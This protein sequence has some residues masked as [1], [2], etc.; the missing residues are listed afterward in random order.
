MTVLEVK[1]QFLLLR[2]LLVS[3]RHIHTYTSIRIETL[4]Y[5][6]RTHKCAGQMSLQA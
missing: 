6:W 4:K 5:L 2:S 3:W 1:T